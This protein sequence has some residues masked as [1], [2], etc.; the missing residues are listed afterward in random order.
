[1]LTATLL[2]TLSFGVLP[3]LLRAVLGTG[4]ASSLTAI[5]AGCVILAAGLWRFRDAL[6]LSVMPGLSAIIRRAERRRPA[7]AQSPDSDGAD[8]PHSR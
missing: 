5:T 2:T 1:L 6:Q 7:V 8:L 4:L 3:L